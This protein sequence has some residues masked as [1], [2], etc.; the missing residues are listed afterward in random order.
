[1]HCL[2]FGQWPWHL[3]YDQCS[4]YYALPTFRAVALASFAQRS[5][6]LAFRESGRTFFQ[7]LSIVHLPVGAFLRRSCRRRWGWWEL[8]S[9]LAL[10]QTTS[11]A[12]LEKDNTHNVRRSNANIYIASVIPVWD[13]LLSFCCC[14]CCC[15]NSY[16]CCWWWWCKSW[17]MILDVRERC[18]MDR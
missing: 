16:C 17:W 1:M 4:C 8:R 6:V 5:I 10:R 2:P 3:S 11:T 18:Q 14:C 13:S 15:C 7:A 9:A 12:I